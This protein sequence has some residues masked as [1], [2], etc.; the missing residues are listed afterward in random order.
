MTD[1]FSVPLEEG[2][3]KCLLCPHLCKIKNGEAGYCRIRRNKAGKIVNE[4]YRMYS[5]VSF[6]PI[7]KKPLYHFY[8]GSKILSVGSVGCNMRCQWCQNCEISQTGIEGS[9]QLVKLTPEDLLKMAREDSR[10]I[11][12][13]YTYN[14]PTINFE[15]IIEVGELFHSVGL[16]NVF[17]SNAYINEEAPTEYL[18]FAD[19]F[20]ID[21]KAFDKSIHQKYTGAK[22][23]PILSNCIKI[24]KSGCHLELT[25]LLVPEVNDSVVSFVSFINWI[26]IELGT[27]TILH[28]SR[29]FPRYNFSK[30]ATSP[31]LLEKFYTLASE[32]LQ[33]VY[34]GNY[35]SE[36]QE[37]TKCPSCGET[38]IVRRGYTAEIIQGSIGGNCWNCNTK[39]FVGT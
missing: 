20:N 32:K 19:A 11:G 13:A 36:G 15:S 10:N 12:I 22:L 8:P 2:K 18:K 5:G 25:F 39:V 17:V 26:S 29:Y 23:E 35:N 6:D 16:K 31:Q 3:V 14:E 38:V 4:A 7:E 21:S 1:T 33:F 37:A 24:K 9:R 30:P 27:D 28:I 34:P